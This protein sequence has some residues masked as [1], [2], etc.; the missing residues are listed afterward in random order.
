VSYLYLLV[1]LSYIVLREGVAWRLAT[2]LS[3]GASQAM[4]R[5]DRAIVHS[6]I[7]ICINVAAL[8][9]AVLGAP[10]W[11][12]HK[13]AILLTT[14]VYMGTVLRGM[15]KILLNLRDF[16]SFTNHLLRYRS[17]G[18]HRWV[19]T[20]IA[21]EVH[22]RFDQMGVVSRVLNYLG[23]GPSRE[24]YV[25]IQARIVV[26]ALTRKALLLTGIFILYVGLFRFV[27]APILIED[28]T[29]F[30]ALQA[31]LWPFAYSM[32]HFLGTHLSGLVRRGDYWE[33]LAQVVGGGA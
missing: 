29:G 32:D 11:W 2:N 28:A 27:A 14:V 12:P 4:E 9:L 5:L 6:I 18:P 19:A 20:R 24:Q 33:M 17:Q 23:G 15:A 7:E 25:E 31:F 1:P 3:L 16:L 13:T 26:E 30:N 22:S 10:H 21:P 8:S